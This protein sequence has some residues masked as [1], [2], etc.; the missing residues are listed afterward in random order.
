[1]KNK[2]KKWPKNWVEHVTETCFFYFEDRG[3]AFIDSKILCSN[4]TENAK[5]YGMRLTF[6]KEENTYDIFINHECSNFIINYY[7]KNYY[8]F[9]KKKEEDQNF[10]FMMDTLLN[11]SDNIGL[12]NYYDLGGMSARD[13]IYNA[14]DIIQ[15]IERMINFHTDRDDDNDEGGENDPIEPFSPSDVMEPELLFC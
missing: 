5:I 1:M 7:Y 11:G 8:R 4:K 13:C 2:L 15:S 9:K 14:Y 3:I 10:V 6:Q 12:F